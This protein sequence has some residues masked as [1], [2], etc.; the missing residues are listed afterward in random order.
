METTPVQPALIPASR[1]RRWG[2]L[3][4]VAI[5]VVVAYIV[6][7][8]AKV[9]PAGWRITAV[10]LATIA[11]LM[12][13][14]L[15]GAVVVLLGICALPPAGGLT[16]AQA[17]AGYASPSVW[18]VVAAMMM[19]RTL[20]DAGVARRI[21]LLFVRAFGRTSLGVSYALIMSDVVLAGS[22]PS[23]TARSA[24]IVL[25]VARN[26]AELYGSSPGQ[27]AARLGTFLMTTVYQGSVVACAMFI[28]GQASNLLAANLAAKFAGVTVTWSSWFLA[29]LA[30]GL[31]S[32]LV[33]PLIVSRL[34]PPEVTQTPAAA[35]Y[36]RAEL[37]KMGPMTRDERIALL[38]A[39][40]VCL[41][42]MTSGWHHLDVTLVALAGA[43]LLL[44]TGVLS[45]E[46]ALRE[47]AA[48]DVFIWYGG[49]ITLG[50]V[51]NSTGSTTAFATSVGSA[52]SGLSWFT[53]L[54]CTVGIFFYAH[55]AFA[56]ITAH[57]LSMFPPFVAMLI[58]LGTPP[59]LAVYALAC[60]ANLTAGLTHYGT[61]S[62]PIV[63]AEGYVSFGDWWRVGFLASLV[64]LAIWLTIG[65]AWWR[66]IGIW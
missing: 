50:D 44:V 5:Y 30:P 15:P 17:L 2:L 55:Y 14:P 16:M 49:L 37:V 62:A 25:P 32:C 39:A 59:G 57:V 33:I 22:I 1:N 65:F 27:T 34:L 10:F 45:W 19:S 18:L 23:I 61:T 51:L 6:P 66:L 47:H 64:N 24:G 38:I 46:R 43:G 28:T 52:F 60:L 56:S 31:V 41:T 4:L 48:W 35:E 26:I 12:I 53:V 11:G 58:G 9:T 42:W 36:A 13:R 63:F 40:G 7:A 8:P 3:V 21:A 54:L 29:G 20:R